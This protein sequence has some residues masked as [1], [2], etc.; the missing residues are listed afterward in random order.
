ME[1]AVI[2]HARVT[3]VLLA[4][5]VALAGWDCSSDESE[6]P[7]GGTPDSGVPDGA[8][9]DGGVPDGAVPDG[10]EAE[11][12][13]EDQLFAD[14]KCP[15]PSGLVKALRE[16]AR[17]LDARA[18]ELAER[19]HSLETLAKTVDGRLAALEKARDLAVEEVDR[20]ADIRAGRCREQ[21][22]VCA[23]KVADLREEYGELERGL[24]NWDKVQQRAAENS[25]DGE[26]V[27]LTKALGSMRP[28]K[29]AATLGALDQETAAMLISK[30]PERSSGKILAALDPAKTAGIVETLLA[31]AEPVN[32]DAL[33]EVGREAAAEDDESDGDEDEREESGDSR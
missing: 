16:R 20:L 17:Q 11:P 10:G 3:L 6:N 32:R 9:P 29:A 7:D 14:G 23:Q 15:D 28:E 27:L 33:R 25:Q 8:V 18:R 4:S 30:L 13:L 12:A 1:D 2:R 5:I 26:I 31:S 22:K 21:E 19:E 24:E